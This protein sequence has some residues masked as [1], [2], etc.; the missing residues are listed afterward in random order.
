LKLLSDDLVRSTESKDIGR[1]EIL[2]DV[3]S[4]CRTAVEILNDLLCFDKLESGIL[5]LHKHEVPVYT[6][7]S[8]CVDMFASQAKECGVELT[9]TSGEMERKLITSTNSHSNVLIE[10]D[11]YSPLCSRILRS[12]TVFM[13]RFKMDQVLR[14]LISN[15]LKFTPKG[16]VVT[17]GMSFIPNLDPRSAPRN[18]QEMVV[19]P[20]SQYSCYRAVLSCQKLLYCFGLLRKKNGQNDNIEVDDIEKQSEDI[21]SEERGDKG[22]FKSICSHRSK[23]RDVERG[24]ASGV[25]T[26]L[27]GV[28]GGGGDIVAAGDEKERKSTYDSSLHSTFQSH[29]IDNTD[30]S[31]CI[32]NSPH[33]IPEIRCY[34]P[35]TNGSLS[36]SVKK[37]TP[38]PPGQF[39]GGSRKIIPRHS[40]SGERNFNKF[41]LESEAA[42]VINGK[43]RIVV[44]DTGAGISEE[45]LRRLF[46]EVVQFNPEVLQA[47]GGSGLGLWITNSIVNL[48]AGVVRAYS[49]GPGMGSS[50]TVEIDMQRKYPYARGITSSYTGSQKAPHPHTLMPST[51]Q[52]SAVPSEIERHGL[53]FKTL[54]EVR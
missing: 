22:R 1:C 54:G 49:A 53:S 12:D 51:I 9:V 26:V 40:D 39:S 41:L 13:D 29:V 31:I 4:A 52:S 30:A 47:G 27:G 14:N 25:R 20:S 7:F 10:N 23:S 19:K 24:S 36:K 5:E 18:A 45:N 43:L 11:E 8:D 33:T 21:N 37:S 17:V 46:V 42:G 34:R 32:G 48:H 35:L 38:S 3:K 28:G 50:F 2:L 16:G 44:T 15:A 6:F